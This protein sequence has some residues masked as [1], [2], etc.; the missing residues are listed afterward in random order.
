VADPDLF[1]DLDA[2]EELVR[3]LGQIRASL[4]DAGERVDRFDHR[5][6]S[7]RIGDALDDFV[8]G[9]KDG[10]QKIIEGIDALI[11][12]CQGASESYIAHEDAVVKATGQT[13]A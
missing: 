2:L 13:R 8:S 6:G 9:W 12:K 1:V 11:G 10:R 3:Q 5:L 4:E 7:V